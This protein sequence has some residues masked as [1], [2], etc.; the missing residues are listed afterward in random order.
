MVKAAQRQALRPARRERVNAMTTT[1]LNPKPE[2]KANRRFAAARGYAGKMTYQIAW[3]IAGDEGNRHAKAHGRK[4]W[5]SEDFDAASRK[6][7]ELVSKH[8]LPA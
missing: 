3:A 1:K 8:N 6:L 4:V 7:D 5:A 2:R